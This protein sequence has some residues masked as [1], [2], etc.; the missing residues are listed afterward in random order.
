MVL[1]KT[2]Q[3]KF[4]MPKSRDKNT[5]K[6]QKLSLR[7]ERTSSISFFWDPFE[8]DLQAMYSNRNPKN[9]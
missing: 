3:N 1:K 2:K 4:S 6:F 9:A 8:S 5:R 7:T